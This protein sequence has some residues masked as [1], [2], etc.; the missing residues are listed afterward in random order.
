MKPFI[1][2][3]IIPAITLL[4]T[5]YIAVF[6]RKIS[7]SDTIKIRKKW[8]KNNAKIISPSTVENIKR[9]KKDYN[10]SITG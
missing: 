1:L 5:V 7:R 10:D 3:N 2:S 8:G 4:F 6:L 9:L